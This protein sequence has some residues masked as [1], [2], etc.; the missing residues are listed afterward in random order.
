MA[1]DDDELI[2]KFRELIWRPSW[3][4]GVTITAQM[5]EACDWLLQ[6]CDARGTDEYATMHDWLA[7]QMGLSPDTLA[8]L[9]APLRAPQNTPSP[10]DPA[11]SPPTECTAESPLEFIG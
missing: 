10:S 5:R 11:T 4:I 3:P 1:K 9:G 7:E 8:P 2:R 6:H